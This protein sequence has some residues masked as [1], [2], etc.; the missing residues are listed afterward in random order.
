MRITATFTLASVAFAFCISCSSAD[1]ERAHEQAN[2][3]EQKAREAVAKSDQE[4][5]KLGSEA[6]SEAKT[7]DAKMNR[8]MQGGGHSDGSSAEQKLDHAGAELKAAGSRAGVKLTQAATIA[9]VKA[10]LASDEGVTT[11]GSVDV[12]VDSAGSV[13]TLTGSV[14]SEESKRQIQQSA[15]AVDGVTKVVNHLTVKP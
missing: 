7:L 4:L 5:K 9:K 15:A 3:A 2:Q 10:K 13:V 11:V 1:K 14:S 12:S 6:K 8:A